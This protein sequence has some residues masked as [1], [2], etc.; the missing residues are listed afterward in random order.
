MSELLILWNQ[1][2]GAVPG[3]LWLFSGA[4]RLLDLSGGARTAEY[5]SLWRAQSFACHPDRTCTA[6]L[7]DNMVL[8]ARMDTCSG[9]ACAKRFGL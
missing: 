2:G 1:A 5:G 9:R 8:R 4:R 6:V 7:L 3:G